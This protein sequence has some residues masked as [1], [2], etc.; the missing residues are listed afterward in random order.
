MLA[1]TP[2]EDSSG[3]RKRVRNA[4]LF[5]KR[6]TV[7]QAAQSTFKVRGPDVDFRPEEVL[8]RQ[9]GLADGQ[10][11]PAKISQSL[12]V[13]RLPGHQQDSALRM[14]WPLEVC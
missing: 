8:R 6:S 7:E 5:C 9:Y 14:Y 10:E 12:V 1:A 13:I 2:M 11:L 4:E 3:V